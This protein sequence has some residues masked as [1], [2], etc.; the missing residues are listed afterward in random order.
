MVLG[1]PCN[2]DGQDLPPDSAPNPPADGDPDR[3]WYPFNSR[4]QFELADL[5]YRC[6]EMPAGR[7]DDLMD[8]F[9]ALDTSGTPPFANHKELYDCIDAINPE[10]TWQCISVTHADANTFVDGDPSVPAWK[11]ATYDMWIRDPKTLIQKQLSNPEIKD[12]IDYAPCQVFGDNHQRVWSDFMTGN[13]A[14]EQC[15]S[16]ICYHYDKILRWNLFDFQNK[17][18]EDQEN[19]GAMFVPIILGSDKTT[20]SVATGNNEYWP[21]YISTG[22]VHNCARRG[23]GQAV[24]LLG[25]LPIPKSESILLPYKLLNI[26]PDD[27]VYTSGSRIR[28]RC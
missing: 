24:N 18:S 13:W 6:D 5:V 10:R 16:F 12:F 4:A 11:K 25:F 28:I 9:A 2:A 17:L 19:H 27:I 3:P 20:V 26:K 8:I 7:L 14:W 1:T 23:H 21:I 15:V 22:N